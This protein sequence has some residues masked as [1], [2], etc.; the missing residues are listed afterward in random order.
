MNQNQNTTKPI[1]I[2]KITNT[3]NGKVYIGQGVDPKK[4]FRQHCFGKNKNAAIYKA[5]VKYGKENFLFE[6]IDW[7]DSKEESDQKEISYIAKFDSFLSGYNLT[8]GGK[9]TGVGNANH[10][11]GVKRDPERIKKM[12][13]AAAKV[14]RGRKL[15]EEHKEKVKLNSAKAK[16]V[17]LVKGEEVVVYRSSR[18]ASQ[19][20]GLEGSS[21]SKAIRTGT[22]VRGWTPMY[23]ETSL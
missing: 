17:K 12:T 9:G 21:V 4:R 18:E 1:A 22:R 20:L 23:L 14:C 5:I 15:T 11:F 16:P 7:C 6:V 10:Q 8:P 13:E 19:I 2:Y 3:V